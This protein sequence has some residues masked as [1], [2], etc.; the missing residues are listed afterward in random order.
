VFRNDGGTVKNGRETERTRVGAF[1][2][3]KTALSCPSGAL[4]RG[5]GIAYKPLQ[6]RKILNPA[7]VLITKKVPLKNTLD[8]R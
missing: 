8:D 5:T 4:R 2:N 7:D 1:F 3:R 6:I